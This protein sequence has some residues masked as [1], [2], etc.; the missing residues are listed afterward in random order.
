MPSRSPH[1]SI[2]ATTS[3]PGDVGAVV[4]RQPV[5][6]GEGVGQ[7]VVGD[8][9]ARRPSAAAA[10]DRRR[11]RT[12]C[13]RSCSRGCG[14]CRR[15]SGSG[16]APAGRS[17]SPRA[18]SA[19]PPRRAAGRPPASVAPRSGGPQRP[20]GRPVRDVMK[21]SCRSP[22]VGVGAARVSCPAVRGRLGSSP[23]DHAASC[24]AK[25]APMGSSRIPGAGGERQAARGSRAS[26]RGPCRP[27]S[28]RRWRRSPPG[29]APS[30]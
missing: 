11:A 9:V 14:S 27:G 28:S 15:W 10:P 4:E 26:G 25:A 19:R 29:S 13:R 7:P 20:A 2:E 16:R 12:A 21:A 24:G 8:G 23:V 17:A 22:S 6:Q 1:R 18:A 30:S 5:A 3:A